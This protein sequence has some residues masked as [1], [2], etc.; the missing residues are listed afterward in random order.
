MPILRMRKAI[1]FSALRTMS[2]D[3]TFTCVRTAELRSRWD[4][5]PNKHSHAT[6]DEIVFDHKTRR[7]PKLFLHSQH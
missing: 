5:G 4:H 2:T 6:I 7:T 1:E 3:H